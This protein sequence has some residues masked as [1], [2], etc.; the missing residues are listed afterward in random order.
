MNSYR[1]KE[2]ASKAVAGAPSGAVNSKAIEELTKTSGASVA[3]TSKAVIDKS[4][5][6]AS[7]A[8][9]AGTSK[10]VAGGAEA[11]SPSSPSKTTIACE[12]CTLYINKKPLLKSVSFSLEVGDKLCIM[13]K[14]GSSKSTLLKLLLGIVGF[15]GRYHL[16]GQMA[17]P[18]LLAE[19]IGYVPQIAQVNF[20]FTLLEVVL[21]G[22]YNSSHGMFYTRAERMLAFEALEKLD[23]LELRDRNFATL[24]GGEK[25]LGLIARALTKNAPILVLDEPTSALDISYQHRLLE[26]LGALEVDNV[27]FTTHDPSHCFIA[28]KVLMM[29]SGAALA[30]GSR[31]A[32]LTPANIKEL[33][34][35]TTQIVPL[36]NGSYYFCPMD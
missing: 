8:S 32:L 17:T 15:E 21:M 33:Y 34:G 7:E 11:L 36:P 26:I 5:E 35:I 24:S 19:K 18:K 9:V 27:I 4:S 3:R 31:E 23:I 22:R 20:S 14:N 13:G 10:E 2:E 29:K 28:N 6:V 16:Y 30:F 1:L 25:Q 12:G